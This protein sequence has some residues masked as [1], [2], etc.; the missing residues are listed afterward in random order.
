MRQTW[1]GDEPGDMEWLSSVYGAPS[2]LKCAI[3]TG[4]EDSPSKIEG[5]KEYNPRL[6]CPPDW[7]WHDS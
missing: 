5:W 2:D 3:L 6:D 4:N 1:L 7:V